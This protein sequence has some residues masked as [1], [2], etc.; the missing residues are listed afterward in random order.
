MD[1]FSRL[2]GEQMDTM[3]RL[4]FIQAE[5]ER[6]QEIERELKTLQQETKLETIQE[7]IAR[8]KSELMEIHQTFEKQTEEL[9]NSYQ[10]TSAM[11]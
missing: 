11:V 1:K 5:L 4:L 3:E 8:M 7:E 9:I 2:V 10:K 6:C